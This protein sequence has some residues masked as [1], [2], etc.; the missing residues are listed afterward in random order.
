MIVVGRVLIAAVGTR[1][2]EEARDRRGRLLCWI[3]GA[4]AELIEHRQRTAR[5]GSWDYKR[6]TGLHRRGLRFSG[7]SK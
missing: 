6:A 5:T 4:R 3:K 2:R 1:R 7:F